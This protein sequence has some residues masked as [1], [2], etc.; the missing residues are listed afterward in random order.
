MALVD[1]AEIAIVDELLT[2]DN[3]E[4]WKV[5]TKNYLSDQDLWGIE[6][7]VRTY[8]YAENQF[9]PW[10][11]RKKGNG[12]LR[13]TCGLELLPAILHKEAWEA[14]AATTNLDEAAAT[15]NFGEAAAATNLDG[16]L[17][18]NEILTS[19]NYENWKMN[20]KN[21]LL[22][23]DL[24]SFVGT[25]AFQ[26]P[27][28]QADNFSIWKAANRKALEILNMSCGEEM[29]P[30]ILY[31]DS[32]RDAWNH[33]ALVAAAS[34]AEKER[35]GRMLQAAIT[36]KAKL[37]GVIEE[38]KIRSPSNHK[39]WKVYMENL[40]KTKYLWGI[41]DDSEDIVDES[42]HRTAPNW[43]HKNREALK[44]IRM[45]CGPEMRFLGEV[46]KAKE[47][48]ERLEAADCLDG[49][50]IKYIPLLQAIQND[51]FLGFLR[52]AER[53]HFNAEAAR[54][55]LTE[56]GLTALHY[57]VKLGKADIVK[58]LVHLMTGKDLEI[59]TDQGQTA[60]SIAAEG[61]NV[62]LVKIMVTKNPKL[63]FIKDG[64]KHIPLVTSAINGDEDVLRYLYSQ[65][66]LGNVNYKEIGDKN[67]ATL[68]TAALR[69]DLFDVALELLRKFPKL[70][71]TKDEYEMTVFNVLAGKPSA[72]P[73]GN[74]F[75][76][77]RTCIYEWIDVEEPGFICKA[78]IAVVPGI[79][80]IHD[81]K[82]SHAQAHEILEIV[83]P[84]LSRLSSSQLV[85]AK[86]C[87]AIYLTTIHGIVEFFTV[88]MNQPNLIDFRDEDGR[89]LFQNAVL[90][91]QQNI[92][93]IISQMG[94]RNEI[95]DSLD[96]DGN[97]ILHCAGIWE[98]SRL[99]KVSGEALQ[100]QREIQWYQEVERLVK[101][102]HREMENKEGLKPKDLFKKQHK[103]LAKEAA[104]WMKETSQ[105]CM[106]VSTLI[107][108]VMFA[109]A[110]TVPGGNDQNTGLPMFQKKRA[111]AIFIVSDAI[112]LF[113]S[114]TSVLMFFSLLTARYAQQD[115]LVSLHRKLI[116]GLSSLFISIATMMA[117]FAATLVIAVQREVWW[118]YIPVT[119]LASVPVILFGLLQLPLF[120]DIVKSTYWPSL[121]RKKT[122][123]V[124]KKNK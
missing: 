11:I 107:A 49:A 109:A 57:A 20:M 35:Y 61:N 23:R 116:L 54:A 55:K 84:L 56:E 118:A 10:T 75:G 119:L 45:S 70:A 5:K 120:V 27:S 39:D 113:S 104:S 43:S 96:K 89:G 41:L 86:A 81:M 90:Y 44:T 42:A 66:N 15:I 82:V 100:M 28:G 26:P 29:L 14:L 47:A 78:L 40:L 21:I 105:A 102:R 108:T 117:A 24:W 76:F 91:R 85:E 30:H 9:Q 6:D 72:F 115:F 22:R 97:N 62:E 64:L 88:L 25:K 68:I 2:R 4:E 69:V 65:T 13:I 74:R 73:S 16:V 95:T 103:N 99:D 31:I 83:R 53:V 50:Y 46:D 12:R 101:L 80:H 37:N 33:L 111:F 79:K 1:L 114:C 106:V 67:V 18:F 52:Y 8:R 77:W 112:S 17:I 58:F 93:D 7:E 48:W 63:L 60:L 32:F 124:K 98:S 3:S 92:F 71:T 19:T 121:P 36:A 34:T 87:E 94:L 123:Y 110:F 122:L 59:K 38:N 51:E